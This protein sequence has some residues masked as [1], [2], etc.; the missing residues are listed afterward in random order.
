MKKIIIIFSLLLS[1]IHLNAASNKANFGINMSELVSM[2]PEQYQQWIKANYLKKREAKKSQETLSEE[3]TNF[4][5]VKRP[6]EAL[7]EVIDEENSTPNR[8][9]VSTIGEPTETIDEENEEDVVI[10]EKSG[11]ELF[12]ADMKKREKL[13]NSTTEWDK[14][15]TSERPD[16]FGK[17][18]RVEEQKEFNGTTSEP[19]NKDRKPK[20]SILKK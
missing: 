2:T 19:F 16:H 12:L 3:L 8:N 5:I 9:F 6:T 17:N 13:R 20:K 11:L 14:M 4:V 10:P 15:P 7:D 18:V 1:T